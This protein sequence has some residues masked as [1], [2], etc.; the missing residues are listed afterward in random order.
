MDLD[1]GSGW[2]DLGRMF[3]QFFVVSGETDGWV[4]SEV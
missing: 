2:T 3:L 4:F 1:F